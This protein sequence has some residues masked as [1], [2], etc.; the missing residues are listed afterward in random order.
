EV[1]GVMEI[2]PRKVKP[3]E[4]VYGLETKREYLSEVAYHIPPKNVSPAKRREVEEVALAAFKA[5]GCRDLSRFDV[6]LDAAGTPNFIEV[7]PLPGLSPV[8]GDVVI[9]SRANGWTYEK[10]VNR[11]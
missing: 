9:L 11:V 2:E 1:L 6:R 5:L 4:F 10:L 8:S 7:N 3:E